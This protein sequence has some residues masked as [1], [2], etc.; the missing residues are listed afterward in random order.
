M[1]T[2]KKD[3]LPSNAAS[4][5]GHISWFSLSVLTVVAVASL[6]SDPADAFY[7]LGS[8][9]YYLV[10]ALL[11]FVPMAL[12]AAELATGW[13]GGVYVWVREAL[14]NRWGFMAI[15]LQ[16][17][18]NVVWYPSQLAFVAAALAY[19]FLDPN[20]A[21]SGFY[22]AVVIIVAYWASTL[23]TLKGKNLFAKVGSWS[24]IIGIFV[25]GFGPD[26]FGSILDWH[27]TA[28]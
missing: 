13:R 5:G 26:Y 16:W 10:P 7:G 8:I 17:I 27:G 21:N 28:Q 9:V 14:G 2:K 23:I 20:L 15:W 3:T 11:F 18:Q 6:R 22:T 25:P 12:V 19:V 24:G 4:G 1:A